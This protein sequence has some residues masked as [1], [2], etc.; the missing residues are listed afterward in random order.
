MPLQFPYMNDLLGSCD[1]R[2]QLNFG[3]KK[4]LLRRVQYEL[5]HSLG[6]FNC[7]RQINFNG[8]NR[9]VFICQGNICRSPLAEA[10]AKKLGIPSQSFG[11]NCTDN[12][13]ADPRAVGFASKLKLSLENHR[14]R[15][16]SHYTPQI[17]DLLVGMEPA[18]AKLLSAM[19]GNNVPI[20]LA[21]LWLPQITPYIHDP[22]NTCQ[23]FFSYCEKLVVESVEALA[24][25]I[26]THGT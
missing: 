9:L 19:F 16:I 12:H 26:N 7:Y 25:Q 2:I 15:H 18:H 13:P 1:E 10:K 6:F 20:T 4:G 17:G 14:T 5:L 24:S 11:L 21:G 8:I 23:E 22:F 3:S